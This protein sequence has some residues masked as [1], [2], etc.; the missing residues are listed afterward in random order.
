M[1]NKIKSLYKTSWRFDFPI[2]KNILIYDAE[3]SHVIKEI[4]NKDCN[5]LNVRQN[6]TI[7]FWI[8]IKQ[9][10]F[11]NFKF[12]TYKINYIRFVSPKII[13][14]FTDNDLKFYELKNT[15]KNINFISIQNGSRFKYFFQSLKNNKLDLKCDYI[16]VFNNFLSSQ[17]K[18]YIKSNYHNIGSLK[19]NHVN[20]KRTSIFG[21][22]L[23][24]SQFNKNDKNY[25]LFFK[26]KLLELINLYISNSDRKLYILLKSQNTTSQ[27]EEIKFYKKIFKSNCV[28]EKSFNWKQSY[29]ILDKHENIIFMFSTLGYE[30]IARKKKV[31]IISPNKIRDFNYHFGWPDKFKLK[32]SFFCTNKLNYNEIKRILNNISNCNQNSWETKYYSLIKNQMYFNRNNVKLKKIIDKLI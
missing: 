31:A 7:Y 9:I 32:N 20:I 12:S 30:A 10:F 6:K 22:F 17:Y 18:K 23:L 3:N 8:L 1:L 4:I 2:K 27:K 15:F 25:I 13:I 24:I 21:H 19:N 28:F 11:L 14:T 5:I 16:F 26:K 29:K